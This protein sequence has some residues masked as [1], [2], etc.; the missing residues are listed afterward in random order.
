MATAILKLSAGYLVNNSELVRLYL[1]LHISII[2]NQRNEK[3][4]IKGALR[5]FNRRHRF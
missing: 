4:T 5:G 2:C 1:N 3:N